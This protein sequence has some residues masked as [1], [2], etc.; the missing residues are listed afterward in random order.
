MRKAKLKIYSLLPVI[1]LQSQVRDFQG[2]AISSSLKKP[3][4][5]ELTQD[6]TLEKTLQIFV[7]V[8]H[9]RPLFI[10]FGYFYNFKLDFLGCLSVLFIWF[11]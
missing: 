3:W 6:W 11:I 2:C 4:A 10:K 1:V 5:C 9:V 8:A 7:V